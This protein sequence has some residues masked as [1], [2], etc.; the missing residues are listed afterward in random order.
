MNI[1][2]FRILENEFQAGCPLHAEAVLAKSIYTRQY[3]VFKKL[4]RQT[5]EDRGVTQVQMSKRLKIHQSRV[6][7]IELGERRMD[8][9]ELRAW[10]EALGITLEG[11]MATLVDLWRTQG[12]YRTR[13][14]R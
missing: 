7:N 2:D 14:R 11:F 5:R 10:C 9:V 3:D 13:A 12:I 6:S 8:V 1:S 4:L